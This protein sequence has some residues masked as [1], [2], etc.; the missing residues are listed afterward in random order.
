MVVRMLVMFSLGATVGYSAHRSAPAGAAPSSPPTSAV[1][2]ARQ[3][4]VRSPPRLVVRDEA[5][6]APRDAPELDAP[7]PDARTAEIDDSPHGVLHGRVTNAA[8]DPISGAQV[9][10]T[11]R[12][13]P[14][15][16]TYTDRAGEYQIAS[17]R[18]S[19]YDVQ[20]DRWRFVQAT[21]SVGVGQLD[22][23]ELDVVLAVAD[24]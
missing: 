14:P 3:M 9:M 7:E 8:G 6:T 17:L 1:A 13:V 12:L 24:E 15:V 19:S 10:A 4:W 11:S 16:F 20:F 18:S 5:V 2:P 23:V 21:R 22:P